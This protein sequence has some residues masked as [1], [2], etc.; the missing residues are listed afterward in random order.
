M[1]LKKAGAMFLAWLTVMMVPLSASAKDWESDDFSIEVPD[2][3]YVFTADTP[4]SDPSW[5]LAGISDPAA[6]L[7]LFQPS[8]DQ[9]MN[10]L[11][12]F[13]GE[14]GS[15]SII[16]TKK[17]SEESWNIFNL[18]DISE[19]EQEEFLGTLSGAPENFTVQTQLVRTGEIPFVHLAYDSTDA[20]AETSEVGEM[21]ERVYGTVLN[22][23]M[24]TFNATAQG[25]GIT[26]E[27]ENL[28]EQVASSMK[29]THLLTK[30][31]VEAANQI[32]PEQL[33]QTLI[34]LG[35]FV[36]LIILSVV[37]VKMRGKQEKKQKK[38]MAD[39]LSAYHREHPSGTEIQGDLLFANVTECSDEAL[40]TFSVY[41]AYVKNLPSMLFGIAMGV[42][43][44]VLILISNSEWWMILLAVALI[45]YQGYKIV[46]AS[47][48]VEKVQRKIYGQGREKKAR[49]AFYG[50]AF[51]V[52]GIQ[53]AMAYP[54]FQITDIRRHKNYIY[55][56]YGPDNAYIIELNGFAAGGGDRFPDFIKSRTAA[57]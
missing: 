46:T 3:L 31:E 52:S 34:I 18:A 26:P 9:G 40:R 38:E 43:L 28:L 45:V 47:S 7:K 41:H 35:V 49:Y 4:V 11:V 53:S 44:L 14:G 36:L 37:F 5:G 51:R 16:L 22:G 39:R 13:V 33:A 29:I 12:N 21:H 15:P 25:R 30:E 24:L 8:K 27:E 54:Y 55:L 42:A 56:Y 50:E 10:A 20:F 48:A 23:Y 6:T 1:K 57:K 17:T 2:G 19:E 32:P